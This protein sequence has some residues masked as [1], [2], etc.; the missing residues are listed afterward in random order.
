MLKAF[1]SRRLTLLWQFPFGSL[2]IERFAPHCMASR[3]PASRRLVVGLALLALGVAVLWFSTWG[4]VS[5]RGTFVV[6]SAGISPIG[7]VFGFLITIIGL[8]LIASVFISREELP[9]YR[10]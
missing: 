8:L 3:A 9:R 1:V 5:Q 2:I 4:S 6:I 10:W 7:V